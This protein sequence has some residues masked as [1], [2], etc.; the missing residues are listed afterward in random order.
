MK[1]LEVIQSSAGLSVKE[2]YTLDRSYSVEDSDFILFG[3]GD[4][5]VFAGIY[6]QNKMARM[7]VVNKNGLISEAINV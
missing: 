2:L 1:L 5:T 6:W 3:E 4:E 7:F